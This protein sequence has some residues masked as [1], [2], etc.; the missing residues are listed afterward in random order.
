MEKNQIEELIAKYNEGLADPSEIKTLE[1]LI[2]SGEV[3]LSRLRELNSLDGQVEKFEGPLPS[4][5]LDSRF[6]AMLADEKKKLASGFTFRFPELNVFLPRFAFA[7]VLIAAG[8][9][10]GYWLQNPPADGKV[11]QLTEQVSEL[12]E[13]MMLSLLQKESATERL[14]AVNL[15]SEMSN[16]SDKV[17]DALFQTLNNDANENVRLAALEVLTTYAMQDKVREGLVRSIAFQDSPVVQVTLAELMVALQ[18]KKSVSELQKL[19]DSDKTP[20]DVRR[21]LEKS[22]EVLI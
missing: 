2:E 16:V 21:K 11:Q 14:R 6:H 15:T 22:V 1:R 13:M 12:K 7:S 8:F 3:E 9:A 20:D 5:E 18:E 19:I 17:T 4:L 10:G